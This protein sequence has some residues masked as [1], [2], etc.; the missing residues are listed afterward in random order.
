MRFTGSCIVI[1]ICWASLWPAES[2]A[3]IQLVAVS[4]HREQAGMHDKGFAHATHNSFTAAWKRL[5][6]VRIRGA[7]ESLIGV[8]QVENLSP[9]LFSRFINDLEEY[10][11]QEKWNNCWLHRP[12]P[13]YY[14]DET[15]SCHHASHSSL[16]Y[17]SCVMLCYDPLNVV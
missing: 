4:A 6:V 13:K 9:V 7:W 12:K 3:H 5:C 15:K 2:A 10:Q 17:C 14:T 8:G 16:Q 1:T 11:V